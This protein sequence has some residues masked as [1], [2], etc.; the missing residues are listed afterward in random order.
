[1]HL[2]K[3]LSFYDLI[4]VYFTAELPT[5]DEQNIIA[6]SVGLVVVVILVVIVAV[7]IVRCVVVCMSVSL[8]IVCLVVILFL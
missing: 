8:Y 5:S 3:W 4:F 7:V 2:Y 6:I 1:M